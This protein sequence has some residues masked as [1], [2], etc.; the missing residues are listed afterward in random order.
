[1]ADDAPAYD[2]CAS[3]AKLRTAYESVLAGETVKGVRLRSG[4]DERQVDFAPANIEELRRAMINARE[5]CSKSMNG[6]G[7]RFAMQGTNCGSYFGSGPR[8]PG[9]RIY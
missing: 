1:M 5:D 6:R 3:Y 4:E 9:G 2:P 7:T 8:F